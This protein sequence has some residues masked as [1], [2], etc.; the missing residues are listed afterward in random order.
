MN[1]MENNMIHTM[2][3]CKNNKINTIITI[4]FNYNQDKTVL[5][6]TRI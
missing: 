5:L 1:L 3:N 6:I 4:Y 2:S